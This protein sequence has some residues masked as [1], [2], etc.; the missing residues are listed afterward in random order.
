MGLKI[1]LNTFYESRSG[2]EALKN[3]VTPLVTSIIM[4]RWSNSLFKYFTFGMLFVAYQ[5]NIVTNYNCLINP[6]NLVV[7]VATGGRWEQ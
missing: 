7:A 1:I 5:Y 6:L 3:Y 4:T 2:S